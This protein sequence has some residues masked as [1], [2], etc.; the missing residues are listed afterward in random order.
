MPEGVGGELE[1]LFACVVAAT[2]SRDSLV[3][4]RRRVRH[5]TNDARAV[6]RCAS[7]EPVTVPAATE[8]SVCVSET[9]GAISASKVG[10][11]CGLTARMTSAAPLDGGRV[12]A[13]R[14]DPVALG[15]LGDALRAAA[16]RNEIG[17]RTPAR[18]EEAAQ[19]RLT[20]PSCTENRDPGAHRAHRSCDA[21]GAPDAC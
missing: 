4:E 18:A 6:G 7:I 12:V 9:A 19:H 8:S 1:V 10:M 17:G 14:L 15:Q 21:R 16:G 20:E 2:D 11:S 13:G 5:R 3:H